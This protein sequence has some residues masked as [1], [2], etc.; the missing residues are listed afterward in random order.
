MGAEIRS[1]PVMGAIL[2]LMTPGP[3]FIDLK[4]LYTKFGGCKVGRSRE[5]VTSGFGCRF[6]F[7]TPGRLFVSPTGPIYQVWW[8]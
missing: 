6:D 8:L 3:L 2:I 5:K 7:W 4:F 1:L